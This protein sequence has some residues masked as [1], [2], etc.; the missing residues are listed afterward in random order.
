[1]VEFV[2]VTKQYGAQIVLSN[3]SFRVAAGEHVGIVGPNGTGKSTLFGMIVGEIMPDG[4]RI[5]LPRDYRLG[6]LRQIVPDVE[7]DLSLLGHVEDAIPGLR[8]VHSEI[9]ELEKAFHDGTIENREQ[10]LRRLGELQT[11]FEVKG[12][13]DLKTRAEVA[14]GGL[15]FSEE[16]FRQPLRTFSGGWRMRAEMAR[17]LVGEPDV[18]LLDEPSNYLDIPAVEWLQRFLADFSGLLLLISHDRYLLNSLTTVTIEVSHAEVTRYAG[19]YDYYARERLARYEQSL[20]ARKNQDRKREQMERFI[21]RFRAKNTLAT[22]VKSKIKALDRMGQVS[23][24]RQVTSPGRIRL[25]RPPHCGHE[26]IRIEEAGV[27]YDGERWV[28]RGVDLRIEKG[29]RI[30]LVG[31]NG[32]GKTTLLRVLADRLALSEGRRIQGHNVVIGYQAQDTTETMAG[33][34]TV[35]ETV[36]LAAPDMSDGELRTLLGGFGFSGDAVLKRIDILS[37]GEKIRV[38]FARLLASPP[39][40]LILDEPPTHLDIDAREALEEALSTYEGTL[41]IVSHDITFVR[42]VASSI[43]SMEPHGIRRWAGDYDYYREKHAAE[44]AGQSATSAVSKHSESTKK[45][46]ARK[47]LRRERARLRQ[48]LHARTKDVKKQIT[49]A[50]VQIERF[51]V[52]KDRVLHSLSTIAEGTDFAGLN[53]RLATIQSEIRAY[54]KRWEDLAGELEE[55][56]VRCRDGG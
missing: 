1:M 19:N 26:I 18:L 52:E 28:L 23:V 22:R 21:E 36:K 29:E 37:G 24:M 12:G 25:R 44:L 13:Y 54:T 47:D 6:Y 7:G 33:N 27:T 49:R 4:G 14:L 11:E 17:V 16:Q 35:L 50:E 38:A 20:A 5:V 15:G 34:V 31:L 51:E 40:F 41:C 2:Q 3:A 32:M 8:R 9:E 30:A 53:K 42:G 46:F 45:E 56:E 55:I 48:E 43:I 39:N 10:G